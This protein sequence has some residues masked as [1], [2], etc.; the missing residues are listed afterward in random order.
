M[1]E[2]EEPASEVESEEAGCEVDARADE[3]INRFHHQLKMQHMDSF[4][5][6]QKRLHRRRATVA[7]E[8]SSAAAGAP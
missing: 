7:P 3:F 1:A 4:M 6:S 2:P 5:R 8:A